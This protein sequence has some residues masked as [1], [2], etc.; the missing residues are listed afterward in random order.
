V[1]R[2]ADRPGA[3][4]DSALGKEWL[5]TNGLGGFAGSTIV[6]LNT[7]RYHGLLV[8]ATRPPVGRMVLLSKFEE[9]LIVAGERFDL[10]SNQYPGA[11]HPQGHLHLEEFRL[12]PFPIFVYTVAGVTIEK[13]VFMLQGENTT[14]IQYELLTPS[15]PAS[16]GLPG[17]PLAHASERCAESASAS[18]A[19]ACDDC[20][21]RQ[22]SGAALCARRCER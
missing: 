11:I 17:L 19:A 18:A 5:E 6:G 2:F 8:A 16:R 3:D 21:L 13:R 14:V 10:S 7:R 22:P 15:D 12:D 9:T 4:L 20:A 1:I